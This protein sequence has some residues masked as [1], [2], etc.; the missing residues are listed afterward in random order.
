MV[1]SEECAILV[2]SCDKNESL[3]NIFFDFFFFCVIVIP[4]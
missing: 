3:L 1:N 2:L 4:C